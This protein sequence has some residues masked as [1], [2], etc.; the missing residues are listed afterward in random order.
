MEMRMFSRMVL[1]VIAIAA[2][3]APAWAGGEGN[4]D[5]G[6]AYS[7][8]MCS[9]CHSVTADATASPVA[10]AK[11]FRS[12]TLADAS[13]PA[14]ASWLNTKHPNISGHI[15]KDTQAEDISAFIDSLKSA[16]QR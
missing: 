2:S 12:I 14:F 5:R 3:I 11:P 6:A 7:V 16:T 1:P 9:S 8:A 4:P 13:G 10:E 15:I